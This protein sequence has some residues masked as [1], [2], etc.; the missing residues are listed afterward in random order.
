MK[1]HAVRYLTYLVVLPSLIW[2]V[3]SKSSLWAVFLLLGAA[4]MLWTPYKRLLP[5]IRSFSFA[6]QIRAI[7]WVPL[8][9]LTGDIAKMIGYPV[10]LG[11]RLRRRHEIPNWRV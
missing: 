4:T 1:R 11:W 5:A 7:L 9:R 3:C 6:D 8:I 2:L 10:G